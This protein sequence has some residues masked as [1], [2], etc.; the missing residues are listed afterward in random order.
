M[1]WAV[2]DSIVKFMKSLRTTDVGETS[3]GG[4]GGETTGV[5]IVPVGRLLGVHKLAAPKRFRID[6]VESL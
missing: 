3:E 2:G 1:G 6:S 5:P 4:P